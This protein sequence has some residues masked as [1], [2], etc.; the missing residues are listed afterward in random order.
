[1]IEKL[2]LKSLNSVMKGHSILMYPLERM[3]LEAKRLK[4]DGQVSQ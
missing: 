1:M 4:D 2:R 3:E